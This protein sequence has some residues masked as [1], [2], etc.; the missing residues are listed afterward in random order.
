MTKPTPKRKRF[1]PS[2]AP[3]NATS[4]C[5]YYE[6]R[7]GIDVVAQ[8]IDGTTSIHRIPW[9]LLLASAKRCRPEQIKITELPR[10]GRDG[11]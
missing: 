4:H 9:R 5:W 2:R 11:K 7:G 1:S 6:Y 8:A 3:Q 10:K